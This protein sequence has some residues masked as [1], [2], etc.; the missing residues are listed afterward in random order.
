MSSYKITF[1]DKI[2]AKTE[3]EAYEILLQYLEFYVVEN[4]DVEASKF[5]TSNFG[6]EEEK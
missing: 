3:E 5:F 1:K 2:E 6:V 4:K